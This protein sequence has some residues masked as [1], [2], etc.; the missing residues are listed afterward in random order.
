MVLHDRS[1]PE[2]LLLILKIQLS[3]QRI[4]TRFSFFGLGFATAAVGAAD[5]FCPATFTFLIM[6]ILVCCYYAAA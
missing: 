5:S 4:S 2:L 3:A 1:F 6:P